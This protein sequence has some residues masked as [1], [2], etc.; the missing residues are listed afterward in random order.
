MPELPEVET[1]ARTI[2][3]RLVGAT[4]ISVDVL[5]PLV[6]RMPDP[7][8]FVDA[9]V[10][11]RVVGVTR[12]G[13]HLILELEARPSLMVHLGMTGRLTVGHAESTPDHARIRFS[14]SSG[15]AL[16]YAD[17][18]KFGRLC[19]AGDA[20]A[21][22]RALGPEPLGEELTLEA[23]LR[24]MKGRRRPIK[25]LLLDQTILAGLGNIYA[26]EALFEAGIHPCTP[27]G[28]LSDGDAARL[29]AAVRG[30]LT[31]GIANRG[32]TISDYVD[33][34]G[35]AGDNQHSLR[36]YGR[37]GQPCVRCGSAM[38]RLRLAG[39]SA[40]YCPACQPAPDAS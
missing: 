14:L 40:C 35:Q 25:S 5:D 37:A 26:D 11:G 1:V 21:Y 10:G 20:G 15:E 4:I 30:V 31:Q 39:R 7:E 24:T 27:S 17:L 38:E 2:R 16:W 13:K 9:L 12:R 19:I 18:R 29:L 28:S 23:L 8:A 6:I 33:A 32:T 34:E 22:L 36:A 3:P